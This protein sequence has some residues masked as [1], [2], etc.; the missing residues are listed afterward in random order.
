MSTPCYEIT[1]IKKEAD[2]FQF[3]ADLHADFPDLFKQWV[4]RVALEKMLRQEGVLRKGQ[5]WMTSTVLHVTFTQKAAAYNFLG[6][7][8][9]LM[10]ILYEE[11]KHKRPIVSRCESKDVGSCLFCPA[12]PRLVWV[13][14]DEAGSI[15]MRL[16]QNCFAAVQEQSVE[17][18]QCGR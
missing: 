11:S 6:R 3:V 2:G 9:K 14:M 4:S 18:I 17:I 1:D 15:Q 13:I 10:S 5:G 8:N 7:L 16:C 12:T